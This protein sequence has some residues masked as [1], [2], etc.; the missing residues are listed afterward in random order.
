MRTEKHMK[1]FLPL[2]SIL[3]ALLFYTLLSSNGFILGNDPAVH[4]SKAY[5]ILNS[6]MISLSINDWYPPFYRVLLAECIIFTGAYSFEHVL[7][8][9]KIL[10]VA[11][12]W[13]LVFSVYLLGTRLFNENVGITSSS[14]LLLCFPIYEINFWGGYPSLLSIMYMYMLLFY[15]SSKRDRVTDKLIA[16]LAAFSIVLTH[17]FATFLT[18]AILIAYTLSA[19]IIFRR[20]LT[21]TFILAVLGASMAFTLWYIPIILPYI[22]VF[23]SHTFFGVKTYLNLT[24][25]VTFDVFIMSFGFIVVFAFLGIPLTFYTSKRKEDLDFY[26]LLCLCLLVPL[27]FSQSYIFGILLPYDRFVYY[28]TP[29]AV[30]F[31]AAVTYLVVKYAISYAVNLNRSFSR[32]RLKIKAL[33]LVFLVVILFASR[34]PVLMGKVYEAASY[35]SFM[36]PQ[37]YEFAVLLSKTFQSEAKVVVSEKPGLFFGVVSGKP[38]IMEVNP[39]VGREADAEVI[40]SMAYELEHPATLFRAYKAPMRYE[41]DQYNV[42]VHGIWWRVAFLF[43]EETLICYSKGGKICSIRVSDLERK[44]FWTEEKVSK[45]LNIQYLLE[46]EFELTKTVAVVEKKLPLC[47]NWTFSPLCS[48]IEFLYFNL[49]I[50]FDPFRSFE[51]AYL[52]GILNWESPWNNP[53]YVEGNRKW[54]VVDFHP[55]NLPKNYVAIHDPV[56]GIFYA[57]KF[58]TCPVWGSLGVLSTNKIDALRLKYSFDGESQKPSISYLVS[59]FSVESFSKVDV[60]AFEKVFSVNF[61]DNFFVVYRDYR[62][63]A[64]DNNV[65]FVVFDKEKFRV[66]FLNHDF[67]QLVFS[68][69]QYIVCK[70]KRDVECHNG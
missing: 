9:M 53:T 46:N 31:A 68:N 67:L 20:S 38:T 51:N 55:K 10:T 70:V 36:N 69:N 52:P 61:T 12:N 14:L 48:G 41:L 8:L 23:I 6:G 34:F 56:N 62:T 25:R 7:V 49:S 27:F 28:L 57:F 33:V 4:L 26:V 2:F 66:E 1:I 13:L 39:N 16:F 43:D 18:M 30:V 37:S 65:Q 45:K 63:C 24:W 64:R 17:H 40:L 44:I 50:H 60:K 59:S 47:I 5:Y 19:L 29:S 11:F 42:L 15:M 22:N 35:Y 32:K 54:A 3:T 21:K 58:E